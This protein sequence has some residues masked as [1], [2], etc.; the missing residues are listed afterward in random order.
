MILHRLR[1]RLRYCSGNM[2]ERDYPAGSRR[3]AG[4]IKS[5]APGLDIFSRIPFDADGPLIDQTKKSASDI[6]K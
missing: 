6:K 3:N 2:R 1:L 5:P 4:C